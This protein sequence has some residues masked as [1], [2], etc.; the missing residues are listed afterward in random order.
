MFSELLVFWGD[1]SNLPHIIMKKNKYIYSYL[2]RGI[3]KQLKP[4]WKSDP[5]KATSFCVRYC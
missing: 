1:C 4:W 5:S 3:T 2:W